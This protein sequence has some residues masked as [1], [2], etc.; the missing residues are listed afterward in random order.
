MKRLKILADENIPGLYHYF[1]HGL[2]ALVDNGTYDD[3]CIETKPGNQIS[4]NSLISKQV[5]LV[6]SVTK[7]TADLIAQSDLNFVGSCTIGT[8]HLDK[9]ALALAGVPWVN[10]PG[11]NANAVAEYVLQ[12]VM[13]FAAHR[14]RSV[15]EL[16]AGIVGYGNVGQ[17]VTAKL[18]AMGLTKI[19]VSDP[20]L[21]AQGAEALSSVAQGSLPE[22][23]NCDVVSL[24]VPWVRSGEHPSHHLIGP[25]V[26][27]AMPAQSLLLNTGRGAVMDLAACLAWRAG[28][29]AAAQASRHWVFD[30][31]ETEPLVD[32]AC[33]SHLRCATPHIAG[34]SQIGKEQG[35]R[36][37]WQQVLTHFN[38]PSNDEYPFSQKLPQYDLLLRQGRL[39]SSDWAQLLEQVSGLMATDVQ[40][41]QG[42]QNVLP[43]DWGKQFELIR[44]SYQP[45]LELSQVRI[46][47]PSLCAED[48]ALLRALGVTVDQ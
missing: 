19:L 15:S 20:P 31:F 41:R 14:E 2:Q 9:S 28:L 17:R 24:H 8:D 40:L 5:L 26:L 34:H 1:K 10:A 11:C 25:E 48:V 42:F 22:I 29:G 4:A 47:A 44:R 18:R 30:V 27:A 13:L 6:R 45:R 35:T 43:A 23:F 12:Q 16:R 33:F 7:V 32:P 46:A 21:A 36:Q 38:L 3:I 37:V 39:A